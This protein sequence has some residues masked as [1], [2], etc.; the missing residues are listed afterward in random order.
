MRKYMNTRQMAEYTGM[1]ESWLEKARLR[2]GGPKFCRVGSKILY[3]RED[4]DLWLAG[5]KRSSTSEAA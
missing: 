1:S 4:A 2:G 3:D 5:C